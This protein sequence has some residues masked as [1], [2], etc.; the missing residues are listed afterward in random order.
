MIKQRI[1]TLF[2]KSHLDHGKKIVSNHTSGYT[3]WLPS[4][5]QIFFF[6]QTIFLG[7]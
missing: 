5:V 7:S 1:S 3:L 2:Y 6:S 4:D